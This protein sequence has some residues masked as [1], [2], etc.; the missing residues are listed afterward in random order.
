MMFHPP[1]MCIMGNINIEPTNPTPWKNSKEGF[2]PKYLGAF[3][4]FDVATFFSSNLWVAML[5][6]HFST[7]QIDLV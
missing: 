3:V 7:K 1:K 5:V 6:I 4:E 2:D